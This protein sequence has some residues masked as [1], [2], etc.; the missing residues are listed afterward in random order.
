MKILAIESSCDETCAAVV[1]DGRRILSNIVASQIETH[2]LYGGV[3]PEIASRAH[4]EAISWV[5]EKALFEANCTLSDIDAIAVTNEPGLIGALLVGVNF[6]KTLAYGCKKPLIPV[7][8]I[9]GHI[10]ANYAHFNGKDGNELLEP[11]F[12]S[13][14]VS[15]GHTSLVKVN[16]YTDFEVIGST[17]DDA[18]G[19]SFDKVARMIGLPYPGG[20]KMDAAAKAGNPKAFAFP[21]TKVKNCPYD[22]SFSGL[23]TSAVNIIH[24]AAQKGEPVDVNDMSASF[25]A[26]VVNAIISRIELLFKNEDLACTKLVLAGGV[27]ANSHLRNALEDTCK[28]HG[29]KFYCPPL[30]LC[31]DNAVMIGCQG[32][33]EYISLKDKDFF[34]LSLNAYASSEF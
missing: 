30:N 33:Y 4:S 13:L 34:N 11:P 27:A 8:H 31:G 7:H 14:V 6:A 18:A 21:D 20:A 16:S 19:E 29:A 22:F 3:V 26:A 32:Y 9:K 12:I 17:R 23:K 25:T 10:A 1:E 5:T 28:K 15:G 24:N 2:A